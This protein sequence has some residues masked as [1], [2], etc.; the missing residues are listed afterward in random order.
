MPSTGRCGAMLDQEVFYY[1]GTDFIAWAEE[2][3]AAEMGDFLGCEQVETRPISGQMANMTL[4]SALCAWRNRAYFKVEPER[5]SPGHHQPY[6]QRR[7]SLGPA[8]GGAQGLYPQRPHY[9]ALRGGELPG[10]ARQ[11]PTASTLPKWP[12]FW[13]STSQSSSSSA[14]AW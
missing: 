7:A 2:R 11:S 8:H 13:T 1:Q 9:R 6:R 4:F 12:I 10:D 5:I 14:K 3:L